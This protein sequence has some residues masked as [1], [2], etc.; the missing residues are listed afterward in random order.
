MRQATLDTR[1]FL[2]C[3]SYIIFDIKNFFKRCRFSRW[4]KMISCI[5]EKSTYPDKYVFSKNVISS[6]RYLLDMFFNTRFIPAS[7]K[8][9][10]LLSNVLHLQKKKDINSLGQIKLAWEN[11]SILDFGTSSTLTLKN[12]LELV[13]IKLG[14]DQKVGRCI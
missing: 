11:C 8:P 4:L 9:P 1:I 12:F 14:D 7:T 2:E 13:C 6:F 3:T 10:G 5:C